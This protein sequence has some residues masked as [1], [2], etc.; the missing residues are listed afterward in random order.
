MLVE[1]DLQ[2]LLLSFGTDDESHALS[3]PDVVLCVDDKLLQLLE[4][5]VIISLECGLVFVERLD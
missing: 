2:I 3:E 1:F 5:G 4:S